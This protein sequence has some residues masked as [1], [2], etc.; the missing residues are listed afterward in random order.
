MNLYTKF[1]ITLVT[2][3]R[4]RAGDISIVELD[5]NKKLDAWM[6]GFDEKIA[7]FFENLGRQLLEWLSS[8]FA[9]VVDI[10]AISC[11]LVIYFYIIKSMFYTTEKDIPRAAFLFMCLLLLRI[12]SRMLQLDITP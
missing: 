11:L 1:C 7:K 3:V 5:G 12:L 6:S 10:I 8:I 2:R 9:W 4:F